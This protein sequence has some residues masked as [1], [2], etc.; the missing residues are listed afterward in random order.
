[1]S[2]SSGAVPGSAWSRWSLTHRVSRPPSSAATATSA[3]DAASAAGPPAQLKFVTDRLIRMGPPWV[4]L[5]RAPG[6]DAVASPGRRHL[7]YS[8]G[9]SRSQGPEL[10]P[11]LRATCLRFFCDRAART[12]LKSHEVAKGNAG[13]VAAANRGSSARR[14][15]RRAQGGD[16]AERPAVEPEPGPLVLR[17]GTDRLVEADARRVPVEHPPLEPVVAALDAD[18]RERAQQLLAQARPALRRRDVQVL[19]PDAVRT[20]PGREGQEPDGAPHHLAIDLRDVGE[21]G[22][23]TVAREQGLPQLL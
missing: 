13:D 9:R 22:R 2:R 18:R 5:H 4:S 3:S 1:M 21:R 16:R 20:G 8:C 11:P 14:R 17:H 7:A 23:R 6:A 19:Q 15:T 10:H 12:A